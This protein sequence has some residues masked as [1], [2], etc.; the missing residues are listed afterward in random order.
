[1]SH[2]HFC[3]V[4]HLGCPIYTNTECISL[5]W[6]AQRPEEHPKSK[7]TKPRSM[8]RWVT[9]YKWNINSSSLEENT[10]EWDWGYVLGGSDSG[11]MVNFLRHNIPDPEKSH[12]SGGGRLEDPE[13]LQHRGEM[14][15]GSQ[16]N[17]IGIPHI[18]SICFHDPG[19]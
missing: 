19:Y 18:W 14:I 15:L 2:A 8:M 10:L 6:A 5:A 7:S 3:L 4:S 9:L 13:V 1:M 11:Y 16:G 17:D 12:Q